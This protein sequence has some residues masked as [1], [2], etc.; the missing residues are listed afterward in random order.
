MVRKSK[1]WPVDVLIPNSV[2][3]YNQRMGDVGMLTLSTGQCVPL[4]EPFFNDTFPCVPSNILYQDILNNH[5][6]FSIILFESQ[7]QL[8]I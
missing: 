2:K 6:Y 4:S 7:I 1:A 8:P 5:Y 3:L